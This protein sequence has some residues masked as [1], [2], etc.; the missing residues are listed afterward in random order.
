M[1]DRLAMYFN[2]DKATHA[3]CLA[4]IIR[5]LEPVGLRWDQGWAN[6]MSA[7]LSE[8]NNAAH[9][10][11]AARDTGATSLAPVLLTPEK[12]AERGTYVG[13]IAGALSFEEY[14]AGLRAAGFEDVVI[15]ATAEYLPGMHSAIIKATKSST[16]VAASI[17]APAARELPIGQK[18]C[19]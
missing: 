13:C 17:D 4:H 2:Y 6:D 11:H 7:L 19:C 9:A 5:A 18:S 15:T 3:I 1:H 8:M 14:E 12:R 10:A 16:P